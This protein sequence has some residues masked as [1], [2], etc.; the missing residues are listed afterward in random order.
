MPNISTVLM[1]AIILV[2]VAVNAQ[3]EVVCRASNDCNGAPGDDLGVMTIEQ[4]CLNTPNSLGFSEGE[5]CSA[6]ISESMNLHTDV[7]DHCSYPF[8]KL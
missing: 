8:S 3:E 7:R 1:L 6:C 2:L 4:C 5:I